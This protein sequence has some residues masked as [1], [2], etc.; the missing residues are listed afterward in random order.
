MRRFLARSEEGVTRPAR[1]ARMFPRILSGTIQPLPPEVR[2]PAT[3]TIHMMHVS[4]ILA[5]K[6]TDLEGCRL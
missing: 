5:L 3:C 1:M 4:L 2:P 6:V